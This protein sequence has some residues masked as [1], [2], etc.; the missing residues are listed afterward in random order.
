MQ[1]LTNLQPAEAQLNDHDLPE[2]LALKNTNLP[3]GIITKHVRSRHMLSD[4]PQQ[5][6]T[7]FTMPSKAR[8]S[9]IIIKN[10]ESDLELEDWMM[11]PAG[12]EWRSSLVEEEELNME[13][14]MTAP[15]K[16]AKE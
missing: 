13:S 2:K 14:W 5:E 10:V 7:I 6:T 11:N 12:P 4:T 9:E 15:D 3:A 1:L 8:L 16:W